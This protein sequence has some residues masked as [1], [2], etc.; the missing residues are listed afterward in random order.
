MEFVRSLP[1]V[2]PG[3]RLGP[4]QQM[5][6]QTS[7]IDASQSKCKDRIQL[8]EKYDLELRLFSKFS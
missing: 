3:C 2:Q 4:R 7:F 1:G 8:S 6:Q 5:N